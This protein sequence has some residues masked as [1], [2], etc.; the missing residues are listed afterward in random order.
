VC[1][2]R[3]AGVVV[4]SCSSNFGVSPVRYRTAAEFFY[5]RVRANL[6]VVLGMDDT[7]DKFRVRYLNCARASARPH[8]PPQV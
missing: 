3:V 4:V 8:A 5:A 6:H 2:W 1:C 7:N